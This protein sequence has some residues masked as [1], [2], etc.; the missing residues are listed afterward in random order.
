MSYYKHDLEEELENASIG[1]DRTCGAL[2]RASEIAEDLGMT[3]NHTILRQMYETLD[4]MYDRLAAMR[5]EVEA[6][7]E[8]TD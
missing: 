5:F 2:S 4:L 1:L 7:D 6:I 8:G 3:V